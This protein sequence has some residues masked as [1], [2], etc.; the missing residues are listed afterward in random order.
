MA[1]GVTDSVRIFCDADL[2]IQREVIDAL[3]SVVLLPSPRGN[4][5]LQPG[6]GGVRVGSEDSGVDER[7]RAAFHRAALGDSPAAAL[8]NVEDVAAAWAGLDVRSRK[9]AVDTLMRVTILP[10]GKGQRFDPEHVGIG[11]RGTDR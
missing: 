6:V 3:Y 5:Q 11:W 1:D 7:A 8:A 4:Q 2:Q 10:A 9:A